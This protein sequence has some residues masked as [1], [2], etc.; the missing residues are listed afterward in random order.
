[1]SDHKHL[2]NVFVQ[3]LEQ[4]IDGVV[5]INAQNIIILYNASAER[6]WGF[7]KQEVIGQNVKVLVPDHIKPNHD[8][9][10]NANRNT[11]ENKIVGTSRDIQIV[12]KDG[13]VRWGAF[14]ISKVEV[15]GE[16]LYT[17]F[18]KDVT[19]LVE[20]RKQIELLSLV[21][22]KTDN[23]IFITDHDWKLTYINQGFKNIFGYDENEVLGCSP[24]DVLA[25]HFE[26][27]KVVKIRENLILGKAIN[28][29]ER[30]TTK[31]GRELWCSVMANAVFDSSGKFSH[32]VTI[33]SDITA[34]KLYEVLHA[35]ILN[36]IAQDEA[37]T[38]IMEAACQEAEKISNGIIPVIFKVDEEGKL[39]LLACSGLATEHKK[40][41]YNINMTDDTTSAIE[42]GRLQNHT[43]ISEMKQGALWNEF[44][45]VKYSSGIASCWSTP[46]KGKNGETIGVIAFYRRDKQKPSDIDYTLA[47]VLAPVCGLAIE[48][49]SHRQ[50][51][52]QLAY[53]DSLT[54][55][56]NRSLLHAEAEQAISAAEQNNSRL[57]VLFLDLDRL[58]FINDTFGHP[59]GD[60]FLQEIASRINHKCDNGDFCGRLSGDE[61]VI[62][63]QN[64]TM[65]ALN[66]F[67]EE[68]RLAI[69]APYKVENT[70]IYPST[71]IGVSVY[72]DD[73]SDIGTL[74]H[75]ADMAMYQAKALGK[76]RFAFFSHE[77]N[78]LAQDRQELEEE[79]EKAIQGNQL[80]FV[81]QPQV[82]M[83]DG[84][85]HGVEALARWVHPKLGF[86]SPA[87]F[88]PL[89][90]ECGLIGDLT[91]W[92]LKSA[93][94]QMSIWRSKGVQV[95]SVS[96]N[97]SPLNFHNKELCHLIMAELEINNL[98]PSDLILELTEGVFLDTN[99][100]TMKT[101]YEIHDKGVCFSIDDFGTGYSSLSYL[102]SIPIKELKLDKSFVTEIE[103]STTSQALSQAVIQ[104]GESLN[105]DVVA[106][107][108]ETESQYKILKE[109][110]Y[111]VAQG[112][113]FSKP[114][115]PLEIEQWL[116]NR[117]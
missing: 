106:E 14:S 1:M 24:I 57:A 26:P 6:L 36:A 115:K 43:F 103:S 19:E 117:G 53:Y 45:Q 37:L 29:E 41:L 116:N 15:D 42:K 49:E 44:N 17:S 65:D 70:Q 84:S 12:R 61:F 75:R 97:L 83:Q 72:P 50:S 48:R 51:I 18:V 71:S 23:A 101:L 56:P 109:Q 46:I 89:A 85:L 11:G 88:I 33:L 107:G 94:K 77:L 27:N 9:F 28:T 60:A 79:L 58:K 4:S 34:T 105:L 2:S 87:K 76:G 39:Q 10:V 38:V 98:Q 108:I 13:S 25:Y 74:I 54:H 111:H 66:N 104:I 3:T 68:L 92:A 80:E 22:D 69:T 113:L 55:L 78:K 5:V 20:Q 35:H 112:Y 95:P 7:S 31:D 40:E 73:G 81:Y 96:V 67:I 52:R 63:S 91:Y 82:K 86:V 16:V 47:N 32:V 21:T 100:N 99:P 110:G 8:N 30:I 114:L 59:A 64:K 93:C 62:V 90:E 102:R